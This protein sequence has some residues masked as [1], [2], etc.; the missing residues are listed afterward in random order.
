[1]R[2]N[3]LKTLTSVRP[4]A[5]LAL[6]IAGVLIALAVD[7]WWE[8]LQSASLEEQVL[9]SLLSELEEVSETT[10]ALFQRNARLIEQA[11]YLIDNYPASTAPGG[12]VEIAAMFASLPYDLQ[13]RTYEEL[14]NSGQF[15]II[16]D[17]D[18]RLLLTEFDARARMLLGYESQM[19]V[20]WN[21]TARPVL[22]R[23]I[24]FGGVTTTHLIRSDLSPSGQEELR[25][26][27]ADRR[28]FTMVHTSMLRSL[29][30]MVSALEEKIAA[31]IGS[32]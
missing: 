14:N 13:L 9:N 24:S 18:L 5:E 32:R 15:Q 17:R 21:E 23:S 28:N 26:V 11:Q 16:S 2:F 7:T 12:V 31:Q 3:S 6:I 22:Y 8:G 1:M 4:L 20:Q 27:I 10:G 30:P 19:Q 25:N 29:P